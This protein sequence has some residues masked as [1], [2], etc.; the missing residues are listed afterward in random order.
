[1]LSKLA[2]YLIILGAAGVKLPQILKLIEAKSAEGVSGLMFRLELIGYTI[3]WAYATVNG[4]PFSTWGE[5]VPL[6][7][8][9]GA[10]LV[11]MALYSGQSLLS[12]FA[13]IGGLATFWTCSVFGF[14]PYTILQLFQ[15]V[16]T[17]IFSASKVPQ[18]VQNF[19]NRST[20]QLSVVTFALNFVGSLTRIGTTLKE[21]NDPYLLVGYIVAAL[22]NGTIFVQILV[23]GGKK[24]KE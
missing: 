10:L 7:L 2:G 15:S 8:Q 19:Q 6:T 5:N 11:L 23:L 9:N 16:T 13:F 12:V 4:F 1:M 18:I 3:T 17:V 20:G 24:K 14:L 22:L 21:V